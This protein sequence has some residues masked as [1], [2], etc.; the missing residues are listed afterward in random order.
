[1]LAEVVQTGK[2]LAELGSGM[3]KCPQHMINVRI[4]AGTAFA[5]EGE[6]G[7]AVS[8]TEQRLGRRGRVLL[9]PSGTEPLVRVMVEGEDYQEV[10]RET[11]QL[12]DL[13]AKSLGSAAN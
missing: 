11:E 12:A 6:V 2:S 5:L 3:K 4:A 13:V 10:V 9:R 8:E 1:M 7:R